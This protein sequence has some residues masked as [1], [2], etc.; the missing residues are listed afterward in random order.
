GPLF[1]LLNATGSPLA[2]FY[3]G[4]VWVEQSK[5]VG[6]ITV[7][8]HYQRRTGWFISNLA[9]HPD[10]RRQDIA[11]QLVAAAIE[12][13]K[14]KGARR[15]S[16]EVRAENSAARALY[17]RLG[18]TEVDSLTKMRMD[19]P[20]EATLPP[21]PRAEIRRVQQGEGHRLQ[22][23]AEDALSP[24]AREILPATE[25]DY[26]ASVLQRL[27]SYLGDLFR[28][29][30]TVHLGAYRDGEIAAL[31]TLRTGAFLVAN[32]LSLMVHPRHRG[33]VE[34]SLLA[35]ALFAVENRRWQPILAEIHPSYELAIEAFQR[36]GFMELETMDL[37]TIDLR[38]F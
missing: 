14:G 10:F 38:R 6:N 18:F 15:I 1:F 12:F 2:N 11:S 37:F 27:R 21:L 30:S 29:T 22:R 8:R 13:A 4:F 5:I 16:L 7:H 24:E 3:S 23:L 20:P 33:Q 36:H 9:V 31:L 26:Q 32:Y 25:R 17:K 28:G 34:E 19:R 35:H